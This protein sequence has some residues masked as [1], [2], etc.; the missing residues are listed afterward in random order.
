MKPSAS[1]EEQQ[2]DKMRGNVMAR[3]VLEVHTQIPEIRQIVEDC[4]TIL[5]DHTDQPGSAALEYVVLPWLDRAAA[6][7]A[8]YLKES[9]QPQLR[10]TKKPS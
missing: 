7:L 3:T 4:A 8:A 10:I 2:R 1:D 6:V 9:A 5:R